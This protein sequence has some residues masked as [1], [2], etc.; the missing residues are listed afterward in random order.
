VEAS[1][2]AHIFPSA[3]IRDRNDNA[4]DVLPEHSSPTISVNAPIRKLPSNSPSS[5]A[6]PVGTTVRTILAGGVRADG[7]F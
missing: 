1:I 6:I 3:V 5:S 2:E 4:T 7:I